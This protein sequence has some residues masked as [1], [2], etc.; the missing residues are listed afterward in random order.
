[1]EE[2]NP[3][4]E[5]QDQI[6]ASYG[7]MYFIAGLNAL[8]GI[9]AMAG[10]EFLASLGLGIFSI[11]FGAVMGILGA[12]THKTHSAIAIGLALLVFGGDW[13]LGIMMTIDAGGSPG[14]GGIVFR[15]LLLAAIGKP[16]VTMF[17]R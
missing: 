1:M 17:R 3:E 7:V 13:I 14:T 9:A 5:L 2:T 11:I 6:K 12:V 15:I 4:A 10:V 16:L 8:L